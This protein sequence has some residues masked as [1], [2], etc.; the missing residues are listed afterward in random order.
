ML[1]SRELSKPKLGSYIEER[2]RTLARY[3]Y[4]RFE[5][6]FRTLARYLA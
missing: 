3:V 4:E 1:C 6:R 2:F 5:E